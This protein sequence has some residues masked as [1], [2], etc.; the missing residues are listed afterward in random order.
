MSSVKNL[1]VIFLLS[2]S[3]YISAIALAATALRFYVLGHQLLEDK[4]LQADVLLQ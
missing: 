1:S 2:I 4:Y 3:T